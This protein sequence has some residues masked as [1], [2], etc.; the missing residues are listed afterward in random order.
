MNALDRRGTE[1][2]AKL[3]SGPDL[4]CARQFDALF[5]ELVWKYLRSQRVVLAVR[6]ARYLG[7][8]GTTAPQIL[9]G[10]VDEVAHDATSRALHR[11]RNNAARF[12]PTKG[13]ITGWVIGAAEFAYV[14]VAK[15]ITNARRSRRLAFVDPDDLLEHAS[16]NPTTEEHVLSHLIDEEALAE[17]ARELTPN[18]FAALRLCVTA[19]YSYAEAAMAIFGDSGRTKQVDGLLTRGK[20]KL[21]LAWAARRPAR[22]SR[23][24]QVSDSADDRSNDE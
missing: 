15:E 6:V 16:A 12:D 22:H 2:L 9:P 19:G 3:A 4:E 11:V 13:S 20:A 5:Y 23:T 1:L 7:V 18:E 21:A 14:E 24:T 17:A 10:E 8:D